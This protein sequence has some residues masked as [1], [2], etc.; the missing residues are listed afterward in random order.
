MVVYTS[1]VSRDGDGRGGVRCLR[2]FVN[3][4]KETEGETDSDAK[5]GVLS[6]SI[7]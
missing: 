7:A 1:E 5:F 3:Q 4:I 6:P 2:S